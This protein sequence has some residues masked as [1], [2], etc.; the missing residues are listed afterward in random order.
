MNKI[1]FDWQGTLDIHPE[2]REMALSLQKAGWEVVIISAIPANLHN[3]R[4]E[5]IKSSGLNLPYRLV[6]ASDHYE[7]GKAKSEVMKELGISILVDDTVNV[8]KAVRDNGL[9]VLQI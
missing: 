8:V 1:A 3:V 4:E 2:L 9:K 7:Q 6:V 5:E